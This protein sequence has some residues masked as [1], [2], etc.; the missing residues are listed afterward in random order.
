ML[1]EPYV[2]ARMK[3]STPIPALNAVTTN[4]VLVE[5]GAAANIPL[6]SSSGAVALEKKDMSSTS[7]GQHAVLK[8]HLPHVVDRADSATPKPPVTTDLS[9]QGITVEDPARVMDSATRQQVRD[10]Q[11]YEKQRLRENAAE[12]AQ[13]RRESLNHHR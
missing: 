8:T 10:N 2:R 5:K 12:E 13:R 7:D 3:E 9:S 6:L 1:V 4:P 11:A